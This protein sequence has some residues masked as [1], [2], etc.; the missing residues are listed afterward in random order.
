MLDIIL[1]MVKGTKRHKKKEA[2]PVQS[3]KRDQVHKISAKLSSL[4]ETITDKNVRQKAREFYALVKG[5]FRDS[6]EIK[7]EVTFQEIQEIIS[8]KKHFSASIRAEVNAFL[9]DLAM[10]EYGYV[11]FKDLLEKKRHEQEKLLHKYIAEMEHEGDHIK[12]KTKK[13]ITRLVAE[14]IPHNEREFLVR[15]LERFKPMLHRIF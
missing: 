13:K 10:M 12:S 7:Y 6:L 8:D 11:E 3:K 4:S 15:M 9:E 14:N 2:S 5:A 1:D